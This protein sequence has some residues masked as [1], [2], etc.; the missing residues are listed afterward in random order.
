MNRP[1][2]TEDEQ[3][4]YL[5]YELEKIQQYISTRLDFYRYYR[6]GSTY[7]DKQFFLRGN[8]GSNSQYLDTFYFERDPAFSTN[9]DFRVAKILANDMLGRYLRDELE[10]IGM[11]R[12]ILSQ[13]PPLKLDTPRWTETKSGLIEILYSLNALGCIDNGNI[14]LSRLT[15]YFEQVFD[16]KLG[17]VSRAFNDMKIRNNRTLF[18]DRMREA[19]LDKI[20]QIEEETLIKK[21]EIDIMEKKK[22]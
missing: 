3:V 11:N 7:L 1:M 4:R 12:Y 18:L 5:N 2:G 9:G 22:K 20:D 17:N 16:I 15:A 14:S 8:K 21:I 13:T 10:K 6:S 19:L